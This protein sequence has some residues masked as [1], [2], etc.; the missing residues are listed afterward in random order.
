MLV[1]LGAQMAEVEALFACALDAR[2]AAAERRL[3]AELAMSAARLAALAETAASGEAAAND[4]AQPV[5][6]PRRRTPGAPAPAGTGR[7]P[8]GAGRRPAARPKVRRRIARTQR[9]A[10]WIIARTT[11]R[12]P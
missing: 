11:R 4:E 7:K 3:L 5:S 6:V 10:D 9:T 8:G 2:D 12:A 1:R